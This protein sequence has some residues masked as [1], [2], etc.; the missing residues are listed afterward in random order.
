MPVPNKWTCPSLVQVMSGGGYAWTSHS[1]DTMWPTITLT[2]SSL[3]P[4]I[5]GGTGR[6]YNGCVVQN[7]SHE[8]E[9]A[10]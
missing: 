8:C 7:E 5:L 3:L 1:N 10:P 4:I 6:K 2:S 9:S